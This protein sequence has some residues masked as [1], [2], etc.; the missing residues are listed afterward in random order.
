MSEQ[1]DQ[2]FY[3]SSI[4]GN[5]VVSVQRSR[6]FLYGYTNFGLNSFNNRSFDGFLNSTTFY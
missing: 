4:S 1:Y 5:R 3:D 6:I 2:S